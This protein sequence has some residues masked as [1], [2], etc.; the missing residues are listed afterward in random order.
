MDRLSWLHLPCGIMEQD[1]LQKYPKAQGNPTYCTGDWVADAR[2][3]EA[4]LIG[5]RLRNTDFQFPADP[6]STFLSSPHAYLLL[7]YLKTSPVM[8]NLCHRQTDA[9]NKK[10]CY[11]NPTGRHNSTSEA[12]D[13]LSLCAMNPP[14][15]TCHY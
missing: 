11:S 7:F 9:N 1:S 15:R 4:A 8:L 14:I 2:A 5:K 3:R 12:N 13:K 10:S 6:M